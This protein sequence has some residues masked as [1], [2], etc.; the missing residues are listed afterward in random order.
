MFQNFSET[1]DPTKGEE[2]A[3]LLRGKLKELSLDG[4]VV[5]RADEHQG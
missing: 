5:P 4:F 1:A 2:R 3:A